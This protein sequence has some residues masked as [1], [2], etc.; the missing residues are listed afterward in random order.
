[1]ADVQVSFHPKKSDGLVAVGTTQSDGMLTLVTSGTPKSGAV[2][3]EYY[4]VIT[5]I[6]AVDD[7]GQPNKS[8][9]EAIIV[10]GKKSN[11]GFT[12]KYTF[13][14]N[15][16]KGKAFARKYHVDQDFKI[17]RRPSAAT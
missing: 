2:S 13:S 15:K 11:E 7:N 14:P 16:N 9:L 10:R 6:V 4:V 3:G 1:L 17:C 12:K 5:K 8:L